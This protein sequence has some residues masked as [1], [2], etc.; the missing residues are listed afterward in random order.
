MKGMV[1]EFDVASPKVLE[2]LKPG[3]KVQGKIK[4]DAGTQIV[5]H[6]EKSP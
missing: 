3:D 4:V 2:G 5:T 6:L 1:M